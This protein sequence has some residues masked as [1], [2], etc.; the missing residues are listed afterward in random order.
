MENHPPPQESRLLIGPE[1]SH[2]TVCLW[3]LTSRPKPGLF[4][5]PNLFHHK[6][7][8]VPVRYLYWDILL[9]L[10]D[11]SYRNPMSSHP[12]RLFLKFRP[13]VC[14]LHYCCGLMNLSLFDHQ[15]VLAVFWKSWQWT[16]LINSYKYNRKIRL[17]NKIIAK[18]L[19]KQFTRENMQIPNSHEKGSASL[20]VRKRAL[21]SSSRAAHLTRC[22]EEPLFTVDRCVNWHKG[23]GRWF[24][25]YIRVFV[26]SV[27]QNLHSSL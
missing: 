18:S 3:R 20:H 16:S 5:N 26:Y 21:R 14:S 23:V 17:P 1:S 24:G 27:S 13:L 25:L 11:L 2:E 22:W 6:C 9:Q 15:I 19:N 4:T 8:P 7:S 10:L 12:W